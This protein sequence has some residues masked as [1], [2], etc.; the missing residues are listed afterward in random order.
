VT[1][2][3]EQEL[4]LAELV[5][6]M[7]RIG[8]DSFSEYL[9]TRKAQLSQMLPSANGM[10]SSFSGFPLVLKF[11]KFLAHPEMNKAFLKI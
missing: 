6:K 9:D 7:R 10:H 2:S 1:S 3:E 4:T 5:P 8:N 11:Q